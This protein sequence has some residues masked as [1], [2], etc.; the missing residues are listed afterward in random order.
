MALFC[1][2]IW[3]CSISQ[4]RFSFLI[5][6]EVIW[7]AIS[8][9]CPLYSPCSCFFFPFCFS[10]FYCLTVSPFVI[11]VDIAL[12]GRCNQF[13]FLYITRNTACTQFPMLVNPFTAFFFLAHKVWL[14][15][16]SAIRPCTLSFLFFTILASFS[17]QRK[18]MVLHWSP[19]DSKSPQVF[20]TFLSILAVL[21]NT[22]VWIIILLLD[23]FFKPALT[24]C[25]SLES[26]WQ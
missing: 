8:L 3:I 10:R 4:L 15:D 18:L 7:C 5:H 16:L 23:I 20:R 11:S 14:R 26:K 6:V 19:S 21:K 9:V 12:T 25:L 2:C 17:Y 1:G 24:D 22:V 13:S